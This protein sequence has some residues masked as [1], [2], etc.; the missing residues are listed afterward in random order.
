MKENHIFNK[1]VKW[2]HVKIMAVFSLWFIYTMSL[3]LIDY[4]ASLRCYNLCHK[5]VF[6]LQSLF[7][8]RV[9]PRVAY[10]FG[11]VLSF[12]AFLILIFLYILEV[13]NFSTFKSLKRGVES[14][15]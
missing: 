1:D 13:V 4:G 5:N 12:A 15:C 8:S 3:I 14:G 9:E 7:L 11:L 6:I 2:S 10:H